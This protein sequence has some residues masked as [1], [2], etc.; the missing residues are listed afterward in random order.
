MWLKTAHTFNHVKSGLRIV[1]HDV[2][3]ALFSFSRMFTQPTHGCASA[4]EIAVFGV[5]FHATAF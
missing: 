4:V 5:D 1:I 2:P 3:L